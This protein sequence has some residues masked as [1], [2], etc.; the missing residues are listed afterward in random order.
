MDRPYQLKQ[1]KVLKV[2]TWP[3]DARM[4][5]GDNSEKRNI[6]MQ[7][8]R[9]SS[10]MILGMSLAATSACRSTG[11]TNSSGVKDDLTTHIPAP[12]ALD[13]GSLPPGSI[14]KVLSTDPLI[15][16]GA[17]A[18]MEINDPADNAL[19]G[20]GMV[21]SSALFQRTI[22]PQAQFVIQTAKFN[23]LDQNGSSNTIFTVSSTSAPFVTQI[24]CQNNEN[25][26]HK[27]FSMANLA[28]IF[29]VQISAPQGATNPALVCAH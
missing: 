26:N 2:G 9:L 12:V 15:V 27:A 17:I 24:L 6:S 13:P 18:S 23:Q 1:P 10:A 21:F 20:C 28:C 4:R 8:Q 7:C 16:P 3:A 11:D 14:L 22:P 29:D 5:S 19:F 25:G